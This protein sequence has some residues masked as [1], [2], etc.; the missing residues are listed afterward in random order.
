MVR[1][2]QME[3]RTDEERNRK[4]RDESRGERTMV[5]LNTVSK[6]DLK[7]LDDSLTFI[8]P[9]TMSEPSLVRE[10]ISH[11]VNV[12]EITDLLLEMVRSETSSQ[13]T[14]P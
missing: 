14:F 13:K 3:R 11:L 4:R 7:N 1:H 10:Y 9:R 6:D 12:H 2:T 8:S 5:K